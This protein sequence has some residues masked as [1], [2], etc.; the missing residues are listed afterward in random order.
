MVYVCVCVYARACAHVCVHARA[1][2]GQK[3]IWVTF[4]Y[5]FP[6]YFL[7]SVPVLEPRAHWIN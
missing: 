1:C 6:L 4:L 5:L 7:K 3:H 2:G